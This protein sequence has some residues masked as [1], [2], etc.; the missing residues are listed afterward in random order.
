VNVVDR[1]PGLGKPLR[2]QRAESQILL[3]VAE[4]SGDTG[5]HYALDDC[6]DHVPVTCR[7]RLS[8]RHHAG[9]GRTVQCEVSQKALDEQV[10]SDRLVER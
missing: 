1:A 7:V 2:I 10:T 5:A 4:T 8:S 3:G 9:Q 6:D